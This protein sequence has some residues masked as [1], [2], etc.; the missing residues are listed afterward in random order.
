M[1]PINIA[2]LVITVLQAVVHM[3][4]IVIFHRRR[5]RPP[6]SY[7][8]PAMS[9]IAA[10]VTLLASLWLSLGALLGDIPIVVLI[11]LCVVLVTG[12]IDTYIILATR[13]LLAFNKTHE[14]ICIS[15]ESVNEVEVRQRNQTVHWLVIAMRNDTAVVFLIASAVVH[16]LVLVPFVVASPELLY[17]KVA[18]ADWTSGTPESSLNMVIFYETI[19]ECVVVGVLAYKVRMVQDVSGV[20]RSLQYAAYSG[21]VGAALMIVFGTVLAGDDANNAANLIGIVASNIALILFVE[22]P[23]AQSY[24]RPWAR[25]MVS[26][27]TPTG[28]GLQLM[29]FLSTPAGLQA[30]KEQLTKEFCVETVLFFEAVHELKSMKDDAD[31]IDRKAMS[32]YKKFIADDA[33]LW[34]N[35]SSQTSSALHDVFKGKQPTGCSVDVFDTALLEIVRLMQHNSLDRFIETHRHMWNEFI[36]NTQEIAILENVSRA[37]NHTKSASVVLRVG[38]SEPPAFGSSSSN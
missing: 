23:V 3:P 22:G 14:Q 28:R 9:L 36:L 30:F 2:F 15:K 31:R 29:R 34:I 4:A 21:T 12:T 32:I 20:K 16:L 27:E 19:V 6:I 25:A 8:Y 11:S 37:I 18:D 7:R 24:T 38:P 10:V 33:P 35:V 26:S 17:K 13:L 1:S 5:D